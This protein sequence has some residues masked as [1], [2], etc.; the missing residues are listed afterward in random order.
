[1]RIAM[2][3]K[4]NPNLSKTIEETVSF[5][6]TPYQNKVDGNLVYPM[7]TPEFQIGLFDML[8]SGG[9]DS[10]GDMLRKT[11][12]KDEATGLLTEAKPEEGGRRF[13]LKDVNWLQYARYADDSRAVNDNF[14]L[15]AYAPFYGAL[16]PKA[17]ET[18][19]SSP[20]TEITTKIKA[21]DIGT[22]NFIKNLKDGTAAKRQTFEI[23][24]GATIAFQELA[25]GVFNV[26]GR[27]AAQGYMQFIQEIEP[28]KKGTR[29]DNLYLTLRT[30]EDF[31]PEKQGYADYSDSFFC[32]FIA[33]SEAIKP[34][35]D[36]SDKMAYETTQ[37]FA[38]KDIFGSKDWRRIYDENNRV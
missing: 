26:V 29:S 10:V 38:N 16:N 14:L 18:V 13:T 25:L 37:R 17:V 7:L 23:M 15:Q 4:V 3:K 32:M 6:P 11:W 19:R 30:V 9:K 12:K 20:M 24:Y 31:L 1:M 22:R 21:L 35:V 5:I 28:S 2:G 36:A 34:I 27:G 8:S 33:Q